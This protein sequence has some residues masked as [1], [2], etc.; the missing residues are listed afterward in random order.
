MI[1]YNRVCRELEGKVTK[2][3]LLHSR[4]REHARQSAFQKQGSFKY[5]S[6]SE[7]FLG[8]T[9]YYPLSSEHDNQ[10]TSLG[11]LDQSRHTPP[12]RPP[13]FPSSASF[14]ADIFRPYLF[15]HS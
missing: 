5:F 9:H 10:Q 13:P 7:S 6:I 15:S 12:L 14:I 3:W 2:S 1:G 8:S 4:C 11:S